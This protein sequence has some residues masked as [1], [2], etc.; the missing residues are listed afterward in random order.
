MF[1]VILQ[2]LGG[3]STRAITILCSPNF[4]HN[5]HPRENDS[6]TKYVLGCV[7]MAIEALCIKRWKSFQGQ[8]SLLGQ[9]ACD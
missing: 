8:K 6:S 5:N 3:L 7:D 1:Q 2:K 9:G 4:D